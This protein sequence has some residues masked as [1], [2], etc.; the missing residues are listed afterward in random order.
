MHFILPTKYAHRKTDNSV[1][2]IY[3]GVEVGKWRIGRCVTEV[4]LVAQMQFVIF[5]CMLYL[6]TLRIRIGKGWA[7]PNLAGMMFQAFFFISVK[8]RCAN[9]IKREEEEVERRKR[10]RRCRGGVAF[11]KDRS[12]TGLNR[13]DNF[14]QR[15]TETEE[16][17]LFVQNLQ[18]QCKS[19]LWRFNSNHNFF[20]ALNVK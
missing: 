19:Y 3:P 12:V 13:L 7:V 1:V 20:F 10:R 18:H 6:K 17:P 11:A 8:S 2:N 5:F 16:I 14:A 9:R 15:I 4:G